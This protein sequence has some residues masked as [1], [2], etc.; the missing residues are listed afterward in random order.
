MNCVT[1][2]QFR[3]KKKRTANHS[4]QVPICAHSINL[5]P[6]CYVFFVAFRQ[7]L[8][9]SLTSTFSKPTLET[10]IS[11]ITITS[12][13]VIYTKRNRQMSVCSYSEVQGPLNHQRRV[14]FFSKC[15]SWRNLTSIYYSIRIPTTSLFHTQQNHS[16]YLS[17]YIFLHW[18]QGTAILNRLSI[19]LATY[20][21][22]T[23]CLHLTSLIWPFSDN[24]STHWMLTTAVF[25]S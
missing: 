24:H 20:R 4:N 3:K 16:C 2:V 15:F 25:D 21:T 23:Y 19:T 14:H 8:K 6:A 9:C 17:C 12:I 1:A 7:K 5:L 18:G 22:I 11:I 10:I 13:Y